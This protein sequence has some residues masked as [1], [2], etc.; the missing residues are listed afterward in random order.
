MTML[1]ILFRPTVHHFE[2]NLEDLFQNFF[3]GAQPSTTQEA[4]PAPANAALDI[5]EE[6]DR[7]EVVLDVPGFTREELKINVEND[8]LAIR[9]ERPARAQ[10]ANPQHFRRV[11]RW[12]GSFERT[13]TLPSTVDTTRAEAQLKDG[14]LKLVLPKKE[15]SKPRQISIG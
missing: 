4:A 10:S 15:T 6:T 3:D 14:V 7:F 12:T 5:Y 2:G 13:L 1:P 8:T 9:G 11:E